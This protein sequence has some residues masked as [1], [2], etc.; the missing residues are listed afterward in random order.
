MWFAVVG[1]L[2]VAVLAW[3]SAGTGEATSATHSVRGAAIDVH[4]HVISQPLTDA[5]TGGGVPASTADDLV[6]RLDEANIEK[7]VVLSLG[8]WD[9]PDDSN[10]APEN[11][12]AASI[13]AEFPDQLIG[14]CGI[15]PRY[16]SALSEVDRCLS[17]SGMQGIKLN[18]VGGSGLDW[19]DPEHAAAISAVLERAQQLDAPVM[20]HVSAAPLDDDSLIAALQVIASHPDLRLAVAHCGGDADYEI[21]QYLI[22]A[23]AV[24]PLINLD[25]LFTDVS[26]CLDFY[27]DAPRSQRELIVWR[28]RKFGIEH[29]FLGSDYLSIAPVQTPAEALETLAKYP[30][31]QQEIRT[32]VENDASMWLDGP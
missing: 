21:E 7:A 1:L 18:P 23:A 26:S 31:T 6:A 4:T 24:P 28:L 8:Y 27:S 17:L 20:M 29:V 12:F 2:T 32:I 16:D 14:F 3:A 10:M 15:N 11:D 19:E 5:L 25:N 30:F 22:P 9:V 13:V